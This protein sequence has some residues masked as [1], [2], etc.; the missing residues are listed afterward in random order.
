M[1]ARPIRYTSIVSDLRR[2]SVW[3]HRPADPR[4]NPGLVLAALTLGLLVFLVPPVDGR[5]STEA[6]P[7][8]AVVAAPTAVVPFHAPAPMQLTVSIDARPVVM[9]DLAPDL[10]GDKTVALT[11]DDG[12]DPQ[13]TPRVL[14]LLRRYDAVA[15][16]CMVGENVRARP[17]LVQDV[18]T[19]GMRLCDHTRTHPTD[20]TLLPDDQQETEIVGARIDLAAATRADVVYFRAPSGAFGDP[21]LELAAEQGMQPLGWSVDLRDWAQPGVPAIVGALKDNVHPG[22]IILMHDGGGDRR[23]TVQALEVTLP[24]LVAEGYRFTF[25]TS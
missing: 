21:M 9:T 4:D 15:T 22:A 5:V 10:T 20:L 6:M 2:R 17:D 23:E 13:W 16:F 3:A 19:A 12:P 14:E 11:F 7:V 24:W 8:P 18:V 25:P 1:I